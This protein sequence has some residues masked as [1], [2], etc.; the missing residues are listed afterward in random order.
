[1][2][3][4]NLIYSFDEFKALILK[5]TENGSFFLTNGDFY[6]EEIDKNT[7]LVR[8]AFVSA[9]NMTKSFNVTKYVDIQFKNDYSTKER[10]ELIENL[11][12]ET[13]IILAIFNPNKNRCFIIF[14]SSKNDEIFENKIN[15]ILRMEE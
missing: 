13:K 2:I 12:Q 6:F 15:E 3:R 8:D 1:M 14:I 9:G 4:S 7:N 5:N 10:F 11:R